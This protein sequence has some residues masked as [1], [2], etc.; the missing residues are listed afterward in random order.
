MF[1]PQNIARKTIARTCLFGIVNVL[2]F[3]ALLCVAAAA[4]NVNVTASAGTANA[5]YT[6][7]KGAFDAINAGT[8]QGMITI[9]I[10]ASTTE[11]AT[12]AVLNSS[13][14][15][16]ASYTSV[17][18]QPSADGVTVA[19]A[20][21]TGRGVIELNG[22]DNV[23][24]NG[25]NPN[26]G[27]TNRNL[28]IQCTATNTTAF[29]SLVRIALATSV[30]TSADNDTIKNL[31][32]IGNATGRNAT[33]ITSTT[34]SENT[35]YG[36]IATAG[37]ST[38][39]ATAAP[40]ALAAVATTI[41]SPATA[42]NLLIDNNNVQTVARGIAVQGAA[43]TVFPGLVISNNLIGN[44]TASAVDQVYS[45][46]ITA[47]G[48]ANG[49]LRSNT[50]YIESF[51]PSSTSSA[52]RA[53]DIGGIVAAAGAGT[54]T[55]E[56]NQVNRAK[57]NAPDFWVAH[58]IN[59]GGGNNHVV[60]NNFVRNI[61]LNTTSGGFYSTTFNAT[62]IR[63]ALGT[64]H[65]IY[66]NSVNLTGTITGATPTI[67]CGLMITATTITGVDA[68]NNIF[69]N[70][71]T[72]GSAT[73]AHVAVFLPS[74]GTSGM[75][76]TLNNNDY[77]NSAA[78]TAQQG[79]GQ[80]GTTAGTGFY[81]QANF[82]PSTT[83]GATNFRNYTSTLSAGGANDN[84]SKK[85]DP[86]FLS[87]TDLHINAASPMVD[88]GASVG[89]GTDIDGQA[90]VPP[91]DIGADEPGGVTPPTNDIAA[92][93]IVNPPSGSTRG[94]GIA[95]AVQASF[96]N[97]GTAA[98][99]SVP[100]R[101]RILD[102][103]TAVVYNQ[104]TTIGP[105]NPGQTLTATFPNAT[106]S[107][108]T[109]TTEA[110][111]ELAGDE[112]PGNNTVTGTV[113][114][115]NA[116][117]GGT[118]TV[119][120]GG[121]FPSLTNAGG[122]FEAINVAGVSGNII[123]NIISDLAGETGANALNSFGGGFTVT[124]KPSGAARTISGTSTTTGLIKLNGAD[125]VTIDGSLSGGTDRSLTITNG[126]TGAT[127]IWIASAGAA[128]GATGNTVKNVILS[129][130]TGAT[131]ISGV[132]A[133]SGTTFGGDA[134]AP[135]SNNTIQNTRVFRVQNAAF[136][137]GPTAAPFDLNWLITGND[138][139][140]TVTA[141]KLTFRGMLIGNA[142]NFNVTNNVINGINSSTTTSSTMTGIQVALLVNGGMVTGNKISDV[143]HNNTT[144]WGSNGLY[145][146]ASSTASNVTVANNFISDVASQGFNGQA[147]T[148]N[149]YGIVVALGGGYKIYH[150]SILLNTNQ[151]AGAA[152]GQTAGINILTGLAAGAVD[153]RD[154]IFASTQTLGTRYAVICNSANTVF[155][156]INYND[157]FAQNVGFIGG[158]ARATLAAWQTG[159]G[160]DANSV[161]VDPLYTT[162]TA[163][164]DLH[165]QS[166][167]TLVN[168]GTAVGVTT[169][170]DGQTRDAM[171]DIGADEVIVNTPG[172]VQFS[173]A[174]Y[175]VAENVAGG[176]AT[177]SVTRT[178]GTLGAAAVNYSTANGTAVG[179][180]SCG[181]N[182]D[183]VT[184]S[185]TLNWADGDG[186]P[187]TFNVTI[188]NE[189]VFENDETVNLALSNAS[190][191]TLGAPSTAVLTITNDDAAPAPPAA[192][193]VVISEFR[194]R[195]PTFSAVQG[196]DGARDE[197]VELYNN[198]GAP[199]SVG[200]TD[201]TGWTLAALSS[202][203]TTII[204]ILT[205]PNGTIIPAR[206][207]YLAV[208]SDA[209]LTNLPDGGLPPTGGYSLDAYA[210][211]DAFYTQDIADNAGV[212][213]FRTAT[214]ANLT[215]ANRLD[216][217]GF[218]GGAAPADLF[219]EGTPLPAPSPFTDG[220][221]AYVRK[222]A[223][224]TPQD[225]N[226]NAADFSFVAPDAGTYGGLV[227]QRGAPGP[228]NCGCNPA[229]LFAPSSPIQ[230]NDTVKPGLIDPTQA[231]TAPPNRIRDTT[232]GGAGTPTAFGTLDI[233]RKFT[234]NTGQPITALR[235]RVVDITTTNTQPAGQAD[236]R[237]LTSADTTANGGTITIIGTTVQPPSNAA[238][239]GGL[240]ASGVVAI[241][242]GMLAAG[243][244]INVRFLL[245][246][247]QQGSFRFFVNVE[248]YNGS[249]VPFSG[250]TTGT[251]TPKQTGSN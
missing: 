133:G 84:A 212:A 47:Q 95:F 158:S 7:L 164:A 233:R 180:A 214:L 184:T 148:D 218:N 76:L 146:T 229:N 136:L 231:S 220:Q 124:I 120:S 27:G 86:Q 72:N 32:L 42:A 65:Q 135:N 172:T 20:A 130:N 78:P 81:T 14:A 15:G 48:S 241:P 40:A 5:T 155:S 237:Y 59:L 79:V 144:G 213:L 110:S 116:V 71:L 248:A 1:T 62:G 88:M 151:G 226:N 128:D 225:T 174:T 129:G 45:V 223:T 28:T 163:P 222:L 234:N 244:S 94:A 134:E 141:D 51:L 90:R 200:A 238:V 36:V 108:G 26:T 100:V 125:N 89:V 171:P 173:S 69:V 66:H 109:Y 157:Y 107:A 61:T 183:Y 23:T 3:S 4:Q 215:L 189:S 122:I 143:K 147:D 35:V 221:Y 131:I 177:I 169:D 216:A 181:A 167:S 123:I 219:R 138:W 207:H 8:H 242:G 208:N 224:G 54:F 168:A 245:G 19:G 182:V 53:I 165:L 142:Q 39:S 38:T 34:G 115:V 105:I 67:T 119:G 29:T 96:V 104:T 191:A 64:G 159:T 170:I 199:I 41:G 101:F 85:V 240:N 9:D 150:N 77:F 176:V 140:S 50:V 232:S 137:R 102:A 249:T 60:R 93:A 10:V 117:A 55:V 57:N 188:C 91:P 127:V 16:S 13:G 17:L 80:V 68:R 178:G 63:V 156:N 97:N 145:F 11:G 126:N 175:T 44:A 162:T 236:V 228:E 31:N 33:G 92:V 192:G 230:R 25:D 118:H 87:P 6:T 211:G 30:V 99:A 112:V 160:Q 70:S 217:V 132:L 52:N 111:S 75:N 190:G 194:F 49:V 239:G 74:G 98:Q 186:A 251:T 149:G 179:G 121:E 21:P 203:G 2:V 152:A 227:A 197:Y 209:G 187:K 247:A 243:S 235:F 43:T 206:A 202:D 46:G 185:G 56:R 22:A 24:I 166:G 12:P 201:G 193:S 195:G 18:I 106:L 58:G 246:V 196:I 204:P 83:A 161:A 103:S 154:N 198:T 250:K 139:G 205:I 210:V 37:A 73:S 153:L 114:V 82:D 113:N